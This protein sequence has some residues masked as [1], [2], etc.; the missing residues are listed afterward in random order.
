MSITTENPILEKW[1]ARQVETMFKEFMS[2]ELQ[3]L[4]P[5]DRVYQ[6][7]QVFKRGYLV[8]LMAIVETAAAGNEDAVKEGVEAAKND[9]IDNLDEAIELIKKQMRMENEH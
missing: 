5:F 7:H 1:R 6:M 2:S 8:S 9:M 3:N 4:Q